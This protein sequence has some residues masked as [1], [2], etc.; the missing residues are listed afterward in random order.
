MRRF[1]PFRALDAEER[2]QD[3]A[4]HRAMMDERDGQMDLRLRTLATRETFFAKLDDAPVR[5]RDDFPID[6]FRRQ[7]LDRRATSGDP[8]VD[9]LVAAARA[10]EGESY[11]VELELDRFEARHYEGADPHLVQVALEDR[12]HTRILA[13][14]CSVFDIELALRRP[15]LATRAV[16]RAMNHLPTRFRIALILAG[17]V[18]GAVFFR[19]LLERCEVFR[20]DPACEERLRELIHEIVVDETGHVAFCRARVDESLLPVARFLAPRVAAGLLRDI[21]EFARLGGGRNA[22]L[23]RVRA[24]LPVPESVGW[25]EAGATAR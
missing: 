6:A 11:G 1:D 12:D 15:G 5:W 2:A 17:E 22:V 23:D 7:C 24:A 13:R 21:P 20:A 4:A 16:T 10:N 18:V 8:R 14:V 19:V 9:W 3:L 25:L